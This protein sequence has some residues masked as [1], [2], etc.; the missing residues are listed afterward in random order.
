M[1]SCI[2]LCLYCGMSS[3]ITTFPALF[4]PLL[5]E[6]VIMYLITFEMLYVVLKHFLLFLLWLSIWEISIKLLKSSTVLNL[7][8]VLLS[9]KIYFIAATVFSHSISCW[10]LFRFLFLCLK[11]SYVFT[12]SALFDE[13]MYWVEKWFRFTCNLWM[14]NLI[15]KWNLRRYN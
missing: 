6:G 9:P 8:S 2:Y 3:V 5:L 14:S 12:C 11:Y 15:W 10:F 4:F 7:S 1:L 13:S